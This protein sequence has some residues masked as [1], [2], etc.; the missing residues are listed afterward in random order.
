M[1]AIFIHCA[2]LLL[3]A[4]VYASGGGST[5]AESRKKHFH[6][7][8]E[9]PANKA[10]NDYDIKYVKFNLNFTDT[11]IYISGDVTTHAQVVT[12]DMSVYVF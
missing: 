5:C 11:S 12:A 8:K 10:E 3:V 1:K 6:N 2:L 4:N 9:A 7:S